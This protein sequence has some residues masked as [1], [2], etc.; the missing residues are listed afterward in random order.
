MLNIMTQGGASGSPVFLPDAPHVVG[1]LYGG[2]VEEYHMEVQRLQV[3]YKVPTNFSY[4]VP[5][6]L[7]QMAL[8][9]VHTREELAQPDDSM[10]LDE[11]LSARPGIVVGNVPSAWPPP[12]QQ[13]PGS[14]RPTQGG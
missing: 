12:V 14:G 4:C 6:S 8:D 2:L 3:P 13:Q 1:V 9:R 10:T 7:L 5:G 11:I